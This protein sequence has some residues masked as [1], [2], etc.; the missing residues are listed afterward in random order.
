MSTEFTSTEP[1][2][3]E[4][5]TLR[6]LARQFA[7]TAD[8]QDFLETGRGG[9]AAFVGA[10]ATGAGLGIAS[11]GNPEVGG[12]I[13]TFGAAEMVASLHLAIEQMRKTVRRG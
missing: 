10:L 12:A 13:A 8:E 3:D 5:R 1:G 4:P 9:F 2:N 6:E 7:E 11:R